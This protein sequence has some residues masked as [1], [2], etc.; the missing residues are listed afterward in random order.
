MVKSCKNLKCGKVL[1]R[2]PA[3]PKWGDSPD[4]LQVAGEGGEGVGGGARGTQNFSDF[5]STLGDGE[6]QITAAEQSRILLTRNS[7]LYAVGTCFERK[8]IN[9]F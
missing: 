2:R 5:S 9:R 7:S 6:K 8:M 3:L 1:L 4:G